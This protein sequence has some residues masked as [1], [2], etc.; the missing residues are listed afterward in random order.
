MTFFD[1]NK[2]YLLVGHRQRFADAQCH[3]FQ[4]NIIN[5]YENTYKTRVMREMV[6]LEPQELG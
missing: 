1:L 3:A 2:N 5:R 4:N 6:E